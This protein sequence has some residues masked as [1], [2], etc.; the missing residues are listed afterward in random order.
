MKKIIIALVLLIAMCAGSQ[1]FAKEEKPRLGVLRFTNDT[2]AGWWGSTVGRELQDMLIAE[3]ASTKAFRVL[4][5]KE[6]G[7]V[8][9]EQ[10]LGASGRISKAQ[11]ILHDIGVLYWQK[12]KR[13]R[14]M[15]IKLSRPQRALAPNF[16][17][18]TM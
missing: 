15:I 18:T 10:D 4:E 6:L 12:P 16:L 11:R 1:A 3:L 9:K 7:D 8:I 2:N 13:A 5:R 14:P 17:I